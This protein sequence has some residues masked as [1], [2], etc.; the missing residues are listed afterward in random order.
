MKANGLIAHES[1]GLGKYCLM[2]TR[3]TFKSGYI[4]KKGSDRLLKQLLGFGNL[5]PL[6]GYP[7][8]SDYLGI[9]W[10]IRLF[11]IITQRAIHTSLR[12]CLM[13]LR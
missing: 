1:L 8:G 2:S 12:D 9:P 7:S 5:K 11:G 4:C 13:R 3:Q 10:V 6:A